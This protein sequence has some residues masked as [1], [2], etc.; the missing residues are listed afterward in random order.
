MLWGM[1]NFDVRQGAG[2]AL[3]AIRTR[4]HTNLNG[5]P[6]DRLG[7]F[8]NTLVLSPSGDTG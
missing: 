1:N 2:F 5:F 8:I 4:K 7:G 3:S 6:G